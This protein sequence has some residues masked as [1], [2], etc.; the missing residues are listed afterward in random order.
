MGLSIVMKQVQD[1]MIQKRHITPVLITSRST[2]TMQHKK[3]SSCT[4]VTISIP[5]IKTD[6]SLII[7]KVQSEL[8]QTWIHMVSGEPFKNVIVCGT[9][10]KETET[11]IQ[12]LQHIL[13][14]IS[15]HKISDVQVQV[16]CMSI[17]TNK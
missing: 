10:A 17:L 7:K 12:L 1:G 3:N 15:E 4:S 8:S 5:T 13:V 16:Y 9:T 11:E 2:I 6:G 14:D